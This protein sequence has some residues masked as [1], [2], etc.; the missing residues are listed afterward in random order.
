MDLKNA[1]NRENCAKI[2]WVLERL[3]DLE[4]SN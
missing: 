3:F 4:E 1:K 2:L